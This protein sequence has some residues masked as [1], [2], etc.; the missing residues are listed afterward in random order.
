MTAGRNPAIRLALLTLAIVALTWLVGRMPPLA[1]LELRLEDIRIAWLAPA[2]PLDPRIVVVGIDEA[3]LARLPVRSPL[4][5]VYLARV[6]RAVASGAPRAIAID[7]VLDRPSEPA[8]D[9]AL[10]EALRQSRAPVVLAGEGASTRVLPA[11]TG[12]GIA[13]ADARLRV[14]GADDVVRRLPA[15]GLIE[16][17]F[18]A[19][20]AGTHAQ[21]GGGGG[22]RIAYA[23]RPDGGPTFPVVQ[24]D[25]LLN[26]EVDPAILAGHTVLIGAIVNDADRHQVPVSSHE[27]YANGMPGVLIH[28]YQVRT[29]Q[30][31]KAARGGGLASLAFAL[32]AALA[33]LWLWR[34]GRCDAGNVMV[35]IVLIGVLLPALLIGALLAF[36]WGGLLVSLTW[37]TLA[38]LL[39]YLAGA[40]LAQREAGVRLEGALR[41]F[42]RYVSSPAAELLS[43]EAGAEVTPARAIHT[44]VLVTDLEDF[45]GL[46]EADGPDAIKPLLDGYLDVI[47]AC[48]AMHDGAID[49]IVGDGVHAW[50][51]ERDGL[52][53]AARRA[54]RSALAI[55][56]SVTA[57]AAHHPE[58]GPR[59]TRIGVADGEALL[60]SFGTGDRMDFTLHGVVVHVAARL[61]QE[62]KQFGTTICVTEG[63][64]DACRDDTRWRE[65]G[66]A[67]LRGLDGR[68]RVFTPDP[69][70]DIA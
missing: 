61:E 35:R 12:P 70:D 19:R 13:V 37:T 42:G 39:A 66:E 36:R 27:L 34:G 33:G 51:E 45:S 31:G 43:A 7:I 8:A 67:N 28:A 40:V 32:A 52:P 69:G 63:I 46:V 50:F 68:Y 26:G 53:E 58:L 14:D 59:R 44:A 65:L 60:G 9:A 6:L 22:Q 3:A 4:D 47:T 30:D 15:A 41:Q 48:V 49:K 11:F 20:L 64:A 57:F 23:L 2:A 24:S 21:G 5:R 54:G 17:S 10:A 18:A 29:L 62:N 25:A 16:N 55:E 38:F 1:L 56:R